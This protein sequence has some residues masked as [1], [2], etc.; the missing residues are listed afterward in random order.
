[1]ERELVE[2]RG[3]EYHGIAAAAFV[4]RTPLAKVRA[5]ATTAVSAAQSRRLL[6][7]CG[8]D[9]VLGTGG[10]VSAP[11]VIGARWAGRPAYLLEPN[12]R[13]GSANRWMSRFATGCFLGYAET[14]D[15]LSVETVH[16]GVPVRAEFSAIGNLPDGPLQLLILGGSQGARQINELVPAA[17]EMLLEAREDSPFAGVSVLH[18]TGDAHLKVVE[19]D[20]RERALASASVEIVPFLADVAAAM[21]SSH[22]VISRAGALTLAEICAAGRPS[23]LVPLEIAAGHQRANAERLEAAGA[24][25]VFT[26][27]EDESE[28]S[29]RLCQMLSGVLEDRQRLETMAR[30]ARALAH[31]YAACEIADFLE[32][33][34][35]RK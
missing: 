20:Y 23:L 32:K 35:G 10:Y 34:G 31:P 26:A 15:E 16:T 33:V 19:T 21:A 11:A 30:A 5:L 2:G 12:A 17:L 7:R 1:M 22:L 6:R 24:A 8:V 14:A 27:R 29:R 28:A 4:G 18:Q 13:A 3:L 9:V 25:E